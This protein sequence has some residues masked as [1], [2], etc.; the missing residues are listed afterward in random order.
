MTLLLLLLEKLMHASQ[1]LASSA[2]AAH[3]AATES[4][5]ARTSLRGLNKI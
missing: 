3:V 5:S 1:W 2:L 4:S